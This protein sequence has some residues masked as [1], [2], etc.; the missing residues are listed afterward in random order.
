MSAVDLVL[1]KGLST[2]A[3]APLGVPQEYPQALG[4]LGPH[5]AGRMPF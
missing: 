3:L 1:D 4:T 2:A 5:A